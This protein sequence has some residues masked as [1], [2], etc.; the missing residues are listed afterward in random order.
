MPG[1]IGATCHLYIGGS[2]LGGRLSQ[3]A[4]NR[5]P[6]LP[7]LEQAMQRKYC[8][9]CYNEAKGVYKAGC[10]KDCFQFLCCT[11]CGKQGVCAAG[12]CLACHLKRPRR[13]R[14]PQPE[15]PGAAT[16]RLQTPSP[17]QAMPGTPEK[18]AVLEARRLAHEHLFHPDDAKGQLT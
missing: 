11:M 1:P 18:I 5:R 6:W 16:K 14:Q 10:C 15:R 13:A 17:T 9:R 4:S 2:F 7:I 8:R 12:R 3:A